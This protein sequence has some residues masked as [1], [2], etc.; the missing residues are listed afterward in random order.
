MTSCV[1]NFAKLHR[2][3]RW[4]RFQR[5][6]PTY[7]LIAALV[8]GYS[9]FMY[10]AGDRQKQDA[11]KIAVLQAQVAEMQSRLWDCEAGQ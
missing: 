3:E 8:I 1:R 7:L 5:S 10:W 2:R 6:L 9:V 11:R 4:H